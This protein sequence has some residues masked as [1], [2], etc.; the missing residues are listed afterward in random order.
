MKWNPVEVVC[1]A[2]IL[3]FVGC[4]SAPEPG[5]ASSPAPSATG[6]T[7]AA[8]I[9]A[10]EA[11]LLRAAAA[12]AQAAA[13]KSGELAPLSPAVVTGRTLEVP[14]QAATIAGRSEFTRE[15]IQLG[16]LG[17]R[18]LAPPEPMHF[19]PPHTD[20]T[21][22]GPRGTAVKGSYDG[23][24]GELSIAATTAAPTFQFSVGSVDDPINIGGHPSDANISAGRSAVCVT[25]RAALACYTK[26]GRIL[27]APTT[28]ATF[29]SGFGFS[30]IFDL[31][32]IYDHYRDRFWVVGITNWGNS[33]TE[34]KLVIAV[35]KTGDPRDG[36]YQYWTNAYGPVAASGNNADY[37]LIA[38]DSTAVYITNTVDYPNGSGGTTRYSHAVLYRASQ[39]AAGMSGSELDGWRFWNLTNP[40]GNIISSIF[41]PVNC[42]T[43]TS[44][45]YF[46]N[47]RGSST[48]D[49]YALNNP[50]SG[51]QSWTVRSVS[52]AS[53]GSPGTA[54]QLLDAVAG[55][56]KPIKFDNLGT[57]ALDA[58]Y[59]SGKIVFA[60]NDER[61]WDD[62]GD[63][64]SVR[65]VKLD[66][67]NLDA[68]AVDIDRTFG[69][70]AVGETDY[71]AYGWAG[72]GL[73]ASSEIAL[74]YVRTGAT[75]YPQLRVSS[76]L[77]GDSDIRTSALAIAGEAT[78]Q[79]SL[80]QVWYDTGSASIDPVDDDAIYFAQQYPTTLYGDSNNNFRLRVIKMFGQ[81]RPDVL[82]TALSKSAA[83]AARGTSFSVTVTMAN[84]GD[85]TMP[86]FGGEVRLSSN[87]FVST[88]DTLCATTSQAALAAT[89]TSRTVTLSCAV[90]ASLT[91]GT[92][93]VGALLD[94][95]GAATENDESNNS[96]PSFLSWPTIQVL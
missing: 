4:D 13:E 48:I 51:S 12:K 72:V 22:A 9:A 29:F 50:L 65:L 75:I 44:R 18:E 96:N 64:P 42:H 3:A 60:T 31:R 61:N 23:G 63:R 92:Y 56:A 30:G 8:T 90:P 43:A 88:I 53:F 33:A 36:F 94:A 26:G 71:F 87:S 77:P 10:Q 34:D 47:R 73:N 1:A 19:G 24:G 86:A 38:V 32:T 80:P 7:E 66:V 55:T 57:S 91:P 83:S 5:A 46:L 28:A 52:L 78:F 41:T 67:S 25:A 17:F 76:W 49:V 82:P 37:P 85:A 62:A 14:G 93:Y 11:E 54:P 89:T 59:R 35:S 21:A 39:M 6:S 45:G 81:T 16:L 95:A 58:Q 68:I 2:T 74:A 15:Q 40:D 70:R 20:A 84:D 27:L 69:A 79:I